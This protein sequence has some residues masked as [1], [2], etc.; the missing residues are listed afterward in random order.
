MNSSR[1]KRYSTSRYRRNRNRGIALVSVLWLLLLLSGL[2]ATVAYVARADSVLVHRSLD[3]S[4][5][6]AAADAAI[7]NAIANLSDEQPGRHFAINGMTQSWEFDD[8]PV[9]VEVTAET[10]R[11]DINGA[12]DDLLLAFL[13]SR[14]LTTDAAKTLLHDL[15]FKQNPDNDAGT[16]GAE[17]NENRTVSSAAR[18]LNGPLQSLGELHEIPSWGSQNLDC[19]ERSLTVYSG[20][21]SVNLDGATAQTLAAVDWLRKQSDAKLEPPVSPLNPDKSIIGEVLRIR[22]S[23]KMSNGVT[24]TRQWVGR[25]TGDHQHPEL[26]M[27][28]DS[29]AEIG[30]QCCSNESTARC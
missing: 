17:N 10:S 4:R 6:Q 9:A 12:S 21:P 27:L 16:R 2:A 5:A 11:I 3:F 25:L 29:D 28:W 26:T 23:T 30:N 22:A 13:Q 19:W 7:V 15:R 14:G 8:L 18:H 1:S 20:Q 24:A